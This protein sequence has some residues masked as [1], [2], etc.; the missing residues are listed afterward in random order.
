MK[1]K[2]ERTFVREE[3]YYKLRDWI[4]EG[5]YE[6]GKQLR[7][8]DLAEKMGVSRTPIR[9]ALLKLEDEGL[10]VT[11]PNRSTQV[12][13]IDFA[14]ARHLYSIVWCLEKLALTQAFD[15]LTEEHIEEMAKANEKFL[16]KLKKKERIAA[17]NADNDFHSVIVRLSK[18]EELQKILA[19]L[20]QKLKRIDLYYFEKV[21]DAHLSYEE[22]AKIIAAL[23]KKDL[24]AALNAIELN[25]K[26]SYSR[27]KI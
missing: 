12:C 26:E 14:A 4:V 22:H 18:N 23:K 16:Q 6:P 7:D 17:W 1:E 20:K 19:D 25:W 8:K 27:I 11:K 10:V 2:I 3:A 9:E 21:Q 24:N 15:S 5:T 13:M